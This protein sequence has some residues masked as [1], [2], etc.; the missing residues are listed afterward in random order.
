[1][2]D[3]VWPP[4]PIGQNGCEWTWGS[5][6]SCVAQG[7]GPVPAARAQATWRWC[8]VSL[9]VWILVAFLLNSPPVGGGGGTV[10]GSWGP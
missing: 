10:T 7:L 8:A 4:R 3:S 9:G 2:N 5:R 1:M 6:A